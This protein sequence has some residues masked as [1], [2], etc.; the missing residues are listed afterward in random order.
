VKSLQLTLATLPGVSPPPQDLQV[1]FVNEQGTWMAPLGRL[2]AGDEPL[3]REVD[4]SLAAPAPWRPSTPETFDP[5]TIRSI[6]V[7]WGGQTTQPG[8]RFGFRVLDIKAFR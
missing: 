1:Q 7:G 4:L 3:Q 6:L 5:A 2:P 8:Q